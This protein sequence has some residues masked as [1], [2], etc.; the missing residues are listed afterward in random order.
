MTK[1]YVHKKQDDKG[2]HEVHKPGCHKM[3]REEN[4]EYL[5]MFDRC[6]EAVQEARKRQY[7]NVN[8]CIHC[9]NDCHTS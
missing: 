4:R 8:G 6:Q 1:Y 5:G 7:S 2:D 3:P 9:S